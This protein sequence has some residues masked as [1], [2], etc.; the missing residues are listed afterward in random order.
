MI[1]I[2][3]V[4]NPYSA[5]FL[6]TGFLIS[7]VAITTFGQVHKNTNKTAVSRVPLCER[8]TSLLPPF[9][10]KN[11][12]SAFLYSVMCSRK[13]KSLFSSGISIAYIKERKGDRKYSLSPSIYSV[14]MSKANTILPGLFTTGILCA[15]IL[16]LLSDLPA[17]PAQEIPSDNHQNL[18]VRRTL[19]AP[20]HS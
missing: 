17:V 16:L 7:L 15:F 1:Q 18:H 10:A 9:L 6:K 11:P 4:I 13:N 14:S 3:R 12:V 8:A 5:N 19:L 20:S 2:L